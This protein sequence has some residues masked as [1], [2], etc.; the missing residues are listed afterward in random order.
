MLL[1]HENLLMLSDL[2]A[3]RR[4]ELIEDHQVLDFL[5][6]DFNDGK[7]DFERLSGALKI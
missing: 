2:Q 3:C 5:V 7:A 1:F 4:A 6:V